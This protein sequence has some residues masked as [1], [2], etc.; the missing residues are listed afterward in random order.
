LIES[1][2]NDPRVPL[3]KIPDIDCVVKVMSPGDIT[4]ETFGHV[5]ANQTLKY[6]PNPVLYL[7]E[8]QKLLNGG[9]ILFIAIPDKKFTF[10]RNRPLT[11]FDLIVGD[12]L[13]QSTAVDLLD[14]FDFEIS[15][16]H[17]DVFSCASFRNIL[18]QLLERDSGKGLGMEMLSIRFLQTLANVGGY[19]RNLAW[20][21]MFVK[22][23]ATN[24]VA[25]KDE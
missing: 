14:V 3:E 24:P 15:H 10:D 19:L 11:I 22:W 25:Q 16:V 7:R 23:N 8:L 6:C 21:E 5:I 12:Y 1:Y 18:N 13:N 20:S 17:C 2:Q 9:G 4:G